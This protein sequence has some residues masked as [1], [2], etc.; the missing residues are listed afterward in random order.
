MEFYFVIFVSILIIGILI[1]SKI[2]IDRFHKESID[3]EKRLIKGIDELIKRQRELEKDLLTLAGMYE[4]EKKKN[5][6]LLKQL[7]NNIE[8]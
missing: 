5:K 8:N 7:N 4:K 1:I 2:M 6:K 3:S